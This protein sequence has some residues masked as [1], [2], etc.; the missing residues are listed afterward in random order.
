MVEAWRCNHCGEPLPEGDR[1]P[2][3]RIRC[4]RC[5]RSFT[6]A[7]RKV[8]SST[9]VEGDAPGKP[10]EASA[11]TNVVDSPTAPPSTD[12]SAPA[13]GL[14][15]DPVLNRYRR[16]GRAS[17]ENRSD[18]R[19]LWLLI[20]GFAGG[21]AAAL[22]SLWVGWN[23]W[24]DRG[25][26]G[27]SGTV[28][29]ASGRGNS[30]APPPLH[31]S[32]HQPVVAKTL[33]QAREGVVKIEVPVDGG[34][35]IQSGT[36]FVV[37]ARGWIATNYH[38]IEQINDRAQVRF[39]D[40]RTYR[41]QGVVAETPRYD[42]AI[43]QLAEL[44]VRLTVLDIGYD[45]MP[46][47]GT[48]IYSLGHPYN[49]D[50]SL[51]RGIVSRILTTAELLQNFPQHIVAQIHAPQNMIWIQHDAK[52][53]PGNSGGPLLD[54]SGRVLGVNTFVHRLAEYGFASHVRYLRETVQAAGDEVRPLP[55]A[56]SIRPQAVPPEQVVD[57][58]L[59]RPLWEKAAA[60]SWAPQ[61]TQEYDILAEWARLANIVKYLQIRG[62]I[63]PGVPPQVIDQAATE[64]DNLFAGL[65]PQEI[66]DDLARRFNAF[67]E[68]RL[69]SP[70]QGVVLVGTVTALPPGA[71]VVAWGE[72]RQLLLRT[73]PDF[74]TSVQARLLVAGLTT[75]QAAEVRLGEQGEVT[76]MPVIMA[77]FAVEIPASSP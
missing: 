18:K 64:A 70:Q 11:A 17:A 43:L 22:L 8:A 12:V 33:I 31:W 75:S 68:E 65:D 69:T 25:A 59:L 32:P 2:G 40:G 24:S 3:A 44:P 46:E 72:N 14:N 34:T 21:L 28:P 57:T 4:T 45:R 38:L 71:V 61:N 27:A 60:M 53:S 37:D 74:A 7:A 56:P 66:D 52:I 55:P 73:R 77:M 39:S 35:V 6:L 62:E 67:A 9:P 41:L 10:A 1:V 13:I 47:I 63:P 23:W 36:G 30:Q 5:G 54:G 50:F 58:R 48:E 51:S 26:A 16:R 42:L 49:V 29:T 15:D 20:G 76:L 19:P